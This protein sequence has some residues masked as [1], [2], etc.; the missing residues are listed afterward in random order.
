MD[1]KV[2]KQAKIYSFILFLLFVTCGT[3]LIHRRNLSESEL[4]QINGNVIHTE[5]KKGFVNLGPTGPRNYALIIEIENQDSFYGIYAG[6]KD[7][8]LAK[9][10]EIV[11]SSKNKYSFF[12]D[13]TT[14][15]SHNVNLGIRKIKLG[16]KVIY[17][18]NMKPHVVFGVVLII[19]GVLSAVF[20]VYLERKKVKS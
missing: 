1:Y 6:T 13:P 10:N 18:E 3:L 17:Q 19:L 12:I 5:I 9:K 14:G 7:Q 15:K 20:F 2:I 11:L 4:H 8:A 16:D